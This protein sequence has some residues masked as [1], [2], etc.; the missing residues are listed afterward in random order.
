MDT[1]FDI[2]LAD[3]RRLARPRT[4]VRRPIVLEAGTATQARDRRVAVT[5]PAARVSLD[6]WC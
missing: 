2:W 5:P 1:L 4:I 6:P 3:R